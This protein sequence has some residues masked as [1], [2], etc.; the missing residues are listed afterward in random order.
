MHG[1]GVGAAQQHTD[2]LARLH[3]DAPAQQGGNGSSARPARRRYAAPATAPA[4]PRRWP[5]R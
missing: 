3:G 2:P 4:A 1:I 5:H